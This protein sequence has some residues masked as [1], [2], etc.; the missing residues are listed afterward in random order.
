MFYYDPQ[1]ELFSTIKTELEK[2]GYEVYDGALPPND[3]PYPFIY[4]GDM[5][6]IDDESKSA[7]FS[8]IYQTIHV[9][10]NTP[11]NRGT[12]SSMLL[13]IKLTCRSIEKT[14]HYSFYLRN[15]QQRILS[16]NTTKTPLLHGVLEL[17]FKM[18][19]VI[20]K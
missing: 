3:T 13:D 11:K 10:N 5:Q 15:A 19:G 4:L 16:D 12:V 18:K 7:T 6:Q 17:E 14:T 9:W 8:N 2:K 1:Q 20:Q